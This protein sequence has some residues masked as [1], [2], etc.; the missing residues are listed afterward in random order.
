M[1]SELEE[2]RREQKKVSKEAERDTRALP[3]YRRRNQ[4]TEKLR[5]LSRSVVGNWSSQDLS[6]GHL[7]TDRLE[8]WTRSLGGRMSCPFY[9]LPHAFALCLHSFLS[10]Y[11]Y[12]WGKKVCLGGRIR[13]VSCS[14][15][16]S[17]LLQF[18]P[19]LFPLALR[20]LKT[21]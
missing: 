20:T 11:V 5:T 16:P 4:G 15:P 9:L 8:L 13:R 19:F 2:R 7:T 17:Y 10:K 14:Q 21:P 6:P 12:N 18:T 1:F 3:I